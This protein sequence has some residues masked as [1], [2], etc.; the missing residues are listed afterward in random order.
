MKNFSYNDC[1][2]LFLICFNYK[3]RNF[4]ILDKKYSWMMATDDISEIEFVNA[5]EYLI[6]ENKIFVSDGYNY[7]IQ[8]FEII[9][10]SYQSLK[11]YI[12]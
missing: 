4:T 10:N 8:V 1:L 5:I 3:C 7:K 11:L 9:D 2:F 12:F 6:N